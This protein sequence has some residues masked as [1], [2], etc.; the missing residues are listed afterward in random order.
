MLADRAREA[1]ALLVFDEIVTGYR[2]PQHSVQKATGVVPDLTCLG[3]ALASGMP[4]SALAGR[5]PI[6]QRALPS[7]RYGPTFK[8]EIYSFAAARAAIEIYRSEPVADTVWRLGV[9]LKDGINAHCQ[10]IGLRASCVGPPFRMAVIFD[11]PDPY[12]L[13]KK[14]TLYQQELLRQGISTYG[15]IMLPSY[16]H[17]DIVIE[18]T[19]TAVGHAL[20]T[21]NDADRHDDFDRRLEIPPLIDL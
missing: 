5:A 13:R 7:T 18:L 10:R 4:L 8:G 12:R 17:D 6:L 19:L 21:V 16:A 9:K 15:G 11:E 3:K 2:Y 1:G 20:E 14:K